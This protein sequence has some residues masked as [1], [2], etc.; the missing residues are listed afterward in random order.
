MTHPWE[1]KRPLSAWLPGGLSGE[2]PKK[3]S[4]T[5]RP[6]L[7]DDACVQC[8]LCWIYCPEGC[9]RRGET[10]VID[11]ADCRGCGV[12]AAECPKDAIQM[13]EEQSP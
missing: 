4:R 6:V 7:D 2:T 8:H 10:W 1:K 11:L 3:I 9:V 12:C 5:H 13:V